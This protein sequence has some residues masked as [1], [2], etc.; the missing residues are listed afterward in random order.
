MPRLLI[1]SY[2]YPPLGGIAIIRQLTLAREAKKQGWEVAFL[3]VANDPLYL[4][5]PTIST[6]AK[7]VWGYRYPIFMITNRFF[8]RI[9]PGKQFLWIFLDTFY[10][11]VPGAVKAGKLLHEKWPYDVIFATAPRYSSLRVAA[12]LKEEFGVPAIADL[13]DS[14]LANFTFD[15]IHPW[16]HR[17]LQIYYNKLLSKFDKITAVDQNAVKGVD[18]S[19]EIIWNGYDENEFQG[20]MERY[21]DFT[22]SYIGTFYE[23]Y[24]LVPFLKAVRRL[25]KSSQIP[26][27]FLF[28]GS[29]CE[30]VEKISRKLKI[31]NLE[32]M[33]RVPRAKAIEIMR[34]SHVLLSFA[35]DA[36]NALGAKIF[37]CAR[38]GATVLNLS[39]RN[40]DPWRFVEETGLAVN[41]DSRNSKA[42][43]D[44]ILRATERTNYSPP[45]D[46]EMYS[47]QK[48][49][50]QLLEIMEK[51]IN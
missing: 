25:K 41:V 15:Y 44:A 6:E 4:K 7:P 43:E 47:R 50:R 49:A 13:R 37:E 36:T 8:R 18:Y 5:D 23:Q 46:I 3:A 33:G 11:W 14:Y 31:D 30:I 20:E 40:N 9:L 21:E 42:I 2:A 22:I 35:G 16:Y 12:K 24:H 28:V 39:R 34:K 27:K 29:G 38:T 19:Y 51:Q 10:D 48:S 17:F 32:V 1:V 26:L 45:S